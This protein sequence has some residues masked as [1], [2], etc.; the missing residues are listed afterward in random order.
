LGV[1]AYRWLSLLIIF[2]SFWRETLIA[3]YLWLSL[4]IEGTKSAITPLESSPG[5]V[6]KFFVSGDHSFF[7]LFFSPNPNPKLSQQST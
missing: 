3:G 2:L 4:V 6:N 1:N 7:E 5:F